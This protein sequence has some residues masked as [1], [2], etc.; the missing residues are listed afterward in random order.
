V[1][2]LYQLR[3]EAMD[4]ILKLDQS[5]FSDLILL[6][7]D[8]AQ[9]QHVQQASRSRLRHVYRSVQ[10]HIYT[11]SDSE[12][13]HVDLTELI[14]KLKLSSDELKSIEEVISDYEIES[15]D[16]IKRKCEIMMNY[17]K[18]S[19]IWS[20]EITRLQQE[21]EFNAVA[22][23][24]QYQKRLGTAREK[25]RDINDEI[26]QLNKQTMVQLTEQ[27]PRYDVSVI[28]REY[29]K[30]AY[31]S[32]YEDEASVAEHL[33]RAFQLPDLTEEQRR[34]LEELAAEY[35]PVYESYCQQL[36][37]MGNDRDWWEMETE[38]E[39]EK[40]F[41]SRQQEIAKIRFDRD[42]LSTRAAG[43]IARVLREEQIRAIG[44]LPEPPESTGPWDY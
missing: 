19:D 25:V 42:E 30:M 1:R 37:D 22:V 26:I 11:Y 40:D 3:N 7:T 31:P 18:T 36:V 32:V 5:F 33:T 39:G 16:M 10:E 29:S 34:R 24:Q 44:G 35:R 13:S 2:G 8:E 38:D 6:F 17:Q 20:A 4:G 43:T 21:G 14:A 27:L 28:R 15:G 23:G 41:I 9:A 12:T